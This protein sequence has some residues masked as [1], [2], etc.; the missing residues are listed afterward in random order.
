MNTWQTLRQIQYLLRAQTWTGG[1]TTV[2]ASSSVLITAAPREEVVEKIRLPMAI[3][4]P[5]GNTSDADDPDLLEQ[6]VILSLGV[7][8]AGDAYGESPMVGSHRTSQTESKGRGLLEIEEEMF[9]ALELLNTDDG[10]VIQL[11]AS[12]APRP[13]YVSGQ[14]MLFRDYLFGLTVTADRYYH[15]VMNLD[16]A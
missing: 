4:K 11:K 13:E 6:E 8:H 15:P 2:F 5:G 16:Q 3:I 9:N 14:Y 10:V 1:A 12:S 7:G